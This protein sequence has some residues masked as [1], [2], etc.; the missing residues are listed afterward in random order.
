MKTENDLFS[1]KLAKD[2]NSII[3]VDARMSNSS[4]MEKS[5]RFKT[6]ENEDQSEN[7]VKLK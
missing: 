1:A 4:Q 7:L 3:F 5:V 2:D 6:T